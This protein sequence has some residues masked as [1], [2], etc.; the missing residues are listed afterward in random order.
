M[1]PGTRTAPSAMGQG[2]RRM[3]PPQSVGRNRRDRVDGNLRAERKPWQALRPMLLCR[4][5]A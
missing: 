3:L 4:S 5:P 2:A 1:V